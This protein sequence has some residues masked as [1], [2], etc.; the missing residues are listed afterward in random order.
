MRDSKRATTTWSGFTFWNFLQMCTWIPD[1]ISAK[2]KK[3]DKEIVKRVKGNVIAK[4]EPHTIAVSGVG[5]LSV[6]VSVTTKTSIWVGDL[7]ERIQIL[8][9]KRNGLRDG[10]T[11]VRPVLDQMEVWRLGR[12]RGTSDETFDSFE[13]FSFSTFSNICREFRL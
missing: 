12:K 5:R 10:L 3:K 4:P 9:K 8:K 11:L 13:S 7:K 1:L 6:I 2:K